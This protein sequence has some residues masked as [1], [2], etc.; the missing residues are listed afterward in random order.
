MAR[1]LTGLVEDNRDSL[2]PTLVELNRVIGVLQ[3]N[4]TNVSKAIS[5]LSAYATGLGEVVAS[6]PFFTAYV[7]NLAAG[8]LF[9]PA[10]QAAGDQR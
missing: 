4:K 8:N 7:Q 1:Q 3:A 6:G 10:L 2:R 5:G 9:P